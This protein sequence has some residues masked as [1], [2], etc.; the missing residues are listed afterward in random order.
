MTSRHEPPAAAHRAR[1]WRRLG[2]AARLAAMLP[3]L[4]ACGGGSGG[5]ENSLAISWIT[6]PAPVQRDAFASLAQPPMRA[7][8]SVQNAS[9]RIWLRYRHDD[10]QTVVSH[11]FRTDGKGVVFDIQFINVPQGVAGTYADTLTVQICEDEACTR[12]AAGSPTRLPLQLAVGYF[13]RAEAGVAPLVPRQTT[14]LAHDVVAAAYSAALDAVIT[15]SNLPA[16]VLRVHELASGLTRSVALSATPTALSVSPDGLQAAV[17]HERTVSLV[18]LQS[19]STAPLRSLAVPQRVGALSLTGQRVVVFDGPRTSGG[20]S[21]HSVD[22]L[23]EAVTMLGTPP[24]NPVQ[25]HGVQAVAL[26]PAG[27]RLYLADVGLSP[28]DVF[29]LD[30]GQAPADA[31]L[32]DS[33]YHGEHPFCG[34]LA[35]SPDGQ[36]LY[37]GCG[38]LL[39]TASNPDDDLRYIGQLPLSPV[40]P[41]S[42]DS[43]RAPALSVAPDSRSVALLEHRWQACESQFDRLSECHTRLAV[44]DATT[45][46]RRSLLGLGPH[47]RGSD[48][49]QQFGRHLLHRRDGSLIVL[50]EVRT[51]ATATPTWLMHLASP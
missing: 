20:S 50:A 21:V 26:H 13:A 1:G 27:D 28:D 17:G 14:V 37:T 32:T 34:R 49:L 6:T 11:D 46:A 10:S 24:L 40:D 30:L 22:L 25:I 9:G 43:Y 44:H 35:L 7:S 2:N 4:S 38:A 41:V 16:P 19:G 3:L 36:R 12:Q 47:V 23:T 5:T 8:L 29:R 18:Q 42:H 39:G 51:G 31:T 33:P 45:L 48:S 15:V